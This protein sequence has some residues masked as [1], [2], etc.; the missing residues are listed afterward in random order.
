MQRERRG[1]L[2]ERKSTY[3]LEREE[4][5]CRKE[6]QKH[7]KWNERTL[8]FSAN[9]KETKGQERRGRNKEER[10]KFKKED[11]DQEKT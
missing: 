5:T 9:K 2:L 10:S 4:V 3:L 7:Y 8:E 6:Q 11:K 1:Y